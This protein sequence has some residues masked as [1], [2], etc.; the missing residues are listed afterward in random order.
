MRRPKGCLQTPAPPLALTPLF[1][2]LGIT[3]CDLI[4]TSLVQTASVVYVLTGVQHAVH[5]TSTRCCR[6]ISF[7]ASFIATESSEVGT[8]GLKMRLKLGLKA[9]QQLIR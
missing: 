9:T 1:V 6:I 3:L 5:E 2:G 8:L 4:D 7:G